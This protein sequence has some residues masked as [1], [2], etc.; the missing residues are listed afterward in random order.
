[1][2]CLGHG[3][4]RWVGRSARRHTAAAAAVRVTPVQSGGG[5]P[6]VGTRLTSMQV[7][8]VS[9]R[10]GMRQGRV[11]LHRSFGGFVSGWTDAAKEPLLFM[12]P[13]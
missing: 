7:T 11:L 2:W 5:R 13:L 3:L 12:C 10:V 9:W 8:F 6:L 4:M 1:M